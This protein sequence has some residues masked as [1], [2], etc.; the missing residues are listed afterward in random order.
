MVFL[1]L[2]RVLLMLYVMSVGIVGF[3][4]GWFVSVG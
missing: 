1:L 4:V 3:K 2:S